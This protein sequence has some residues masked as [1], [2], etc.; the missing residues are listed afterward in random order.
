MLPYRGHYSTQA[1][2]VDMD[3]RLQARSIHHL[4]MRILKAKANGGEIKTER[5]DLYNSIERQY[6]SS[7][8]LARRPCCC[9][10]Q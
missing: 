3:G 7:L 1:R 10:L 5:L 8:E 9:C 6:S 2:V 4:N